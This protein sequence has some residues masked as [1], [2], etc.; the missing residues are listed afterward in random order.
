MDGSTFRIREKEAEDWLSSNFPRLFDLYQWSNKG[1]PKNYFNCKALLPIAYL[2]VES[3]AQLEKTLARLD[4]AAWENLRDKALPYVTVDDPVR[5][6]QQLFSALDEARGYAFLADEGYERIEFI[7]P[8]K[9]KEGDRKSPDLSATRGGLIAILE[10]KTFNESDPSLGP[11]APWRHEATKVRQDLS[12]EFK[13]KL[14]STI[15]QARKQL[16]GWPHASDR[17]IV[18]LVVRFDIGQKTSAQSYA[19]LE[20]FIASQPMQDGI[21]VYHQA[22]Y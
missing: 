15:E 14:V 8:N 18:L 22:T 6:Y 4:S 5:R 1:D 16:N 20:S 19:E 12:D 11:D 7:K 17:K 21:E 9:N 13:A 2:G 3:Y 10:V